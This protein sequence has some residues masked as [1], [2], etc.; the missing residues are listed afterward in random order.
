MKPVTNPI[1]KLKTFFC[2]SHRVGPVGTEQQAESTAAMAKPQAEPSHWEPAT[3]YW[4]GS[5]I[6][7]KSGGATGS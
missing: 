7:P 4:L 2:K 5:A 3:Y 1:N 6:E